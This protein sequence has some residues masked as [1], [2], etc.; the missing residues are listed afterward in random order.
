MAELKEKLFS[1]FASGVYRRVDGEDYGRL[2]RG[3]V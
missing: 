2:E 3:S 1:E